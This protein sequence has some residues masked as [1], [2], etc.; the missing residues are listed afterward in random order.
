MMF[1]RSKRKELKAPAGKFAQT[2][3]FLSCWDNSIYMYDMN[4]NRCIHRM[5]EAHDDAISR[6][7]L[8]KIPQSRSFLLISASWDSSVK[9]WL[10]SPIAARSSLRRS[11]EQ[12]F[13]LQFLSELSHD[14][15]VVD[16]CLTRTYLATICDD[17]D[18]VLWRINSATSGAASA[19]NSGH[20]LNVDPNSSTYN[21][22][23]K[24]QLSHEIDKM[25]WPKKTISVES[26]LLNSLLK[27]AVRTR[28]IWETR[29]RRTRTTRSGSTG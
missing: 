3:L 28:K 15:A 19:S 10:T 7:A 5:E 14:S 1:S 16:F 20:Q 12:Q 26:I 2:L 24:S 22:I 29:M 21:I 17:G 13:K 18:V 4:Y 23:E 25:H 11:I 9:I 6:L 8:I 27:V